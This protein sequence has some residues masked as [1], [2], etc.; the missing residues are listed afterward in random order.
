MSEACVHGHEYVDGS[1]CWQVQHHKNGKIY[2]N[3]RCRICY[4]TQRKAS[5]VPKP[6][7][8]ACGNGHEWTEG[9]F[10]WKT[11]PN[12]ERW[13]YCLPCNRE[14]QRESYA[15]R[16]QDPVQVLLNT[17]KTHNN[18]ARKMGDPNRITLADVEAMWATYGRACLRC[19]SPDKPTI[20]HVTPVSKGGLNTPDNIQPLCAECNNWK[21]NKTIDYRPALTH[22]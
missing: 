1:W 20:D 12:G 5:Y 17:I 19:E 4:R 15:L 6:S 10:S 11:G 22:S 16:M 3:K 7:P 13:R 2:R 9:S 21:H 8:E 14:R 18:R